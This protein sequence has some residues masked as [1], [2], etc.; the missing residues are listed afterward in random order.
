MANVTFANTMT[1]STITT[2]KRII[3]LNTNNSAL[4]CVKSHVAPD[5]K[6]GKVL[7][8]VHFGMPKLVDQFPNHFE[9]QT[10]N[11]ELL[12]SNFEF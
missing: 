6:S 2:Y 7:R 1:K 9:L 10:L 8:F 3:E 5:V 4:H 12:S 11:F